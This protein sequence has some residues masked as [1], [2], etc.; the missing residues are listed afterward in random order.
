LNFDGEFAVVGNESL[1]A[2]A[3][4]ELGKKA[5]SLN[6]KEPTIR[7]EMAT[8]RARKERSPARSLLPHRIRGVLVGTGWFL[9]FMVRCSSTLN[10]AETQKKNISFQPTTVNTFK[11]PTLRSA[12]ALPSS[13]QSL[14]LFFLPERTLSTLLTL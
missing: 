6:G 7:Q 3:M 2:D 4:D 13:L 10:R 14:S 8:S 1:L 5:V 11:S 9:T 12:F